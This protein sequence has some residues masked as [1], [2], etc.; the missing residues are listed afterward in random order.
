MTKKKKVIIIATIILIFVLFAMC[1]TEVMFRTAVFMHSPK[2]AICM[3]YRK[4]DDVTN[5]KDLYIITENPPI[6]KSTQGILTT[7]IV[8][9]VG[10]LKIVR[11]YGEG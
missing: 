3:K 2:S 8:Y 7:W 9:H 1:S 10:P 11:Y 4:L 6:E 5:G